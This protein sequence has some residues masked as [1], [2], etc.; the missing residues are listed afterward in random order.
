MA[1]ALDAGTRGARWH[2]RI[3]D[4][5]RGREAP[6]A[7]AAILKTLERFGFEWDGPV[8]YQH[9]RTGRYREAAERLRASGA[10]FDCACSRRDV[11]AA[12]VPGLEGPI[13]PGTCR[14]GLPAGRRARSLR[15]R[16]PPGAVGFRDEWRGR[17]SQ[18]VAAAIG[19]FVIWRADGVAAYHLATVLDDADLGVTRVVRG[20]DLLGSTPRQILLQRLLGLSQPAYAHHPLVTRRG[21]KIGKRTRA[22]GLDTEPPAPTLVAALRFLQQSPPADLAAAGLRDVWRW[23]LANWRPA[24]FAAPPHSAPVHD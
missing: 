14:E 7:A 15:L 24:V 11:A 19:D 21:K 10:A 13:Y 4:I 1:S 23:A 18:D 16:V 22:P 12:G 5:D 6:G 8:Q 20:A 2:V 17:V 9:R 3:D